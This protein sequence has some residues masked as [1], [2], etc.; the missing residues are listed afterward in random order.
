M[1]LFSRRAA[2]K[3]CLF[4]ISAVEKAGLSGLNEG[5]VVEFEE[6]A[7]KQASGLLRG[8]W[9][10]AIGLRAQEFFGVLN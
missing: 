10:H 7:D 3:M 9:V 1:D 4:H 6:V 8:A 5:Q 2:E